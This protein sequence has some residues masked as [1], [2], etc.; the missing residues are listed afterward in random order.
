MKSAQFSVHSKLCGDAAIIYPVGYLN[1]LSGESLVKEC[2]LYISKGITKVVINFSET[3]LV[4]S[5]GISLLLQIIEDL[6]NIK[7]TICCTNMSKFLSE[8]FKMLGL[9]Q[10]MH[11][12]QGEKDALKYLT[13]GG[14]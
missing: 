8:T 5:I 13:A 4:N 3:D 7:G 14:K 9:L 6:R 2:G 11:V 1:N 12:F 10:H